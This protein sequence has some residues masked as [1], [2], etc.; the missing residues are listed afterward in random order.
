[1]VKGFVVLSALAVLLAF[2]VHTLS[3]EAEEVKVLSFETKEMETD[4][5]GDVWFGI[6]IKA[7][8]S[9]QPGSITGVV[10]ALDK[11]GFELK[12]VLLH[13]KFGEDEVNIL[14]ERARLNKHRYPKLDKWILYEINKWPG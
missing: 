14:L 11:E 9:G 4:P 6:K 3:E 2:P 5:D 13:K 12:S 1:M 7:S 8:N 10:K